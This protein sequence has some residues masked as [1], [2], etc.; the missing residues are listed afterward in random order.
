MGARYEMTGARII[1][2]SS[3][4]VVVASSTSQLDLTTQLNSDSNAVGIAGF[5]ISSSGS[6]CAVG[7]AGLRTASGGS[8]M[9]ATAS[10]RYHT[11]SITKSMTSTLLAILI[12]SGELPAWNATLGSLLP[13]LAGGTSYASVTL[14]QLVGMLSGIAAN[15]PDWWTY[16]NAAGT[17]RQKRASCAADAL[18]ST[19]ALS[20]GTGYVY[21]NW[22]YVVAGH[23]IEE[24][25]NME[26]EDALLTRLFEPLGICLT[27][28]DAFGAPTSSTDPKGHKNGVPC[29]PLASSQPVGSGYLCDNTPVLGPAGTFSGAL[30]ALAGYLAF[31]VRCHTGNDQSGLLTQAECVRLHAPADAAIHAYGYGWLCVT[32]TW[33]GGTD[34]LACTHTG[35]NGLNDMIVWIAPGIQRA[36]IA[37]ANTP[38]AFTMLDAVV[39]S[40]ISAYSSATACEAAVWGGYCASGP[41][42]PPSPPPSSPLPPQKRP[43]DRRV[44]CRPG[45]YLQPQGSCSEAAGLS[46]PDELHE[47]RLQ[48][49]TSRA[50]LCMC[51]P[52]PYPRPGA[53][54]LRPLCI[55]GIRVPSEYLLCVAR[56]GLA[57]R[58]R[59]DLRRGRGHLPSLR[60]QALHRRRARG[61]LR[62][63]HGVWLR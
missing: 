8:T 41:S 50:A 58:T 39:S 9:P 47:V 51:S 21:S 46:D 17:L 15:P 30:A 49:A 3:I 61:R 13:S 7:A 56:C 19:P 31:H 29:D 14:I 63:R 11:G 6:L 32:R 44:I 23:I 22:A 28:A 62:G 24:T 55:L 42:S 37:Y 48:H 57:V 43:V 38:T 12:H 33:A 54:L 60:R 27:K 52:H 26:W 25:L 35:S 18:T 1:F 59:Q 2:A 5:G 16:H 10:T 53:V 40:T 4:C 34:N 36:F 45:G 20:P